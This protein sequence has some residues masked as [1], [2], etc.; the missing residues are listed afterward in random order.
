MLTG[1]RILVTFGGTQEY[2]DDVRGT[3]QYQRATIAEKIDSIWGYSPL[4]PWCLKDKASE[5]WI[6]NL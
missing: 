4:C 5:K 2:I 3:Y 6:K 1:K